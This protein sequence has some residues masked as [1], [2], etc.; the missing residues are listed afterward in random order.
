LR[1][2]P[3]GW[4]WNDKGRFTVVDRDKYSDHLNSSIDKSVEIL[5]KSDHSLLN[6]SMQQ[7]PTKEEVM[8]IEDPQE[9]MELAGRLEKLK[10]LHSDDVDKYE[11]VTELWYTAIAVAAYLTHGQESADVPA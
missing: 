1:Y 10:E 7:I 5:K 8:A 6:E 9:A 4:G 2:V 3:P 11:E